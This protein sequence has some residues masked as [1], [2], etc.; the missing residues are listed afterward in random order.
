MFDQILITSPTILEILA[1]LVVFLIALSIVFDLIRKAWLIRLHDKTLAEMTWVLLEVTIP[2]DNLK[3]AKA[4][5]QV[6]TSIH[7]LKSG[8]FKFWDT[9]WK[10][11]VEEWISFE[12]MGTSAGIS[13]YMRVPTKKR[14]ML[15]SAFLSQYPNAEMHEAEDYL[16]HFG[17]TLPNEVYD[18]FGLDFVLAEDDHLPIRTY[19]AFEENIEERRIDPLATLFEALSGLRDDQ[20]VLIQLLVR[21]TEVKLKDKAEEMTNKIMGR[22]PKPK[23][24]GFGDF[25]LQFFG[26]FVNLLNPA[27]HDEP[28]WGAAK[29]DEKGGGGNRPSP[30]E[31][32]ILKAVGNKLSKTHFE[33]V[34]RLVYIDRKETFSDVNI[35]AVQ[36]AIRQFNI[37]NL[38]GFKPNKATMTTPGSVGRWGREAKLLAKKEKLFQAYLNREMPQSPKPSGHLETKTSVYSVE[39]LATIY[40]PPTVYVAAS[41]LRHLD[42]KKGSAPS[43]LPIVEDY[44]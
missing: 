43:N 9:W 12:L 32:G 34:L 17:E 27:H 3:S 13:F 10:G 35:T 1:G 19:L 41:S 11:K 6:F 15:E 25:L 22:A 30:V 29:K 40:H 42:A 26:N 7:T 20:T 4:M 44:E 18:L 36:G 5:E 14:A 21:G 16:S 33:C 24:P 23:K 39:E 38:N 37:P 28:T 8:P 31:D 2:R